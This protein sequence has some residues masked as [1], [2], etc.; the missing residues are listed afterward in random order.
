MKLFKNKH[1]LILFF[2]LM[3]L[4]TN[5][6]VFS[7][8]TTNF[9]PEYGITTSNVNLRKQA[10]TNSTNILFTLPKNTNIKIVGTINEFYI[11]ILKDGKVGLVSKDYVNIKEKS[12]DFPEYTNLDKYF[13]TTNSSINVRGGAGTNFQIIDNLKENEK[14]E[15]IGKI[16]NFFLIVTENNTVGMVRDDLIT[17]IFNISNEQIKENINEMLNL[18]NNERE[19]NGLIKLQ[20]LPRLEE[21]ATIKAD[22]MVK[23]NYFSH[24]SPNYGSPFDMMKNFG[25]TY[26]TAGENIAGNSSITGA[27]N[28]WLSSDLHKQNILSSAYNYVGIGISPSEKYGYIIVV[29]FIRKIASFLACYFLYFIYCILCFIIS[30]FYQKISFTTIKQ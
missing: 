16:N 20:I 14:I 1:L 19:K 24:Q 15:V 26:K 4:L 27:F 23:N 13:A 8:S 9:N 21:V 22:D 7:Y 10:S 6:K 5:K 11:V 2:T 25:I 30:K 3:Y 28:S 12:E 29:M 17:K 18:I